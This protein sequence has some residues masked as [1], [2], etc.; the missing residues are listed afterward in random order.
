MW[1][2][3]QYQVKERE[4]AVAVGALSAGLYVSYKVL[5]HGATL[6]Q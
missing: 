1:G 6:A 2:L 5:S 3:A 4:A